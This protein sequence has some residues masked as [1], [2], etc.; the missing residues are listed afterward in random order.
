MAG[1]SMRST[2][3]RSIVEPILNQSFDGVYDQRTDEYKQIFTEE[4]G[5]K[6]AYHEE[7]A[8]VDDRPVPDARHVSACKAAMSEG[9]SA[10]RI[11]A[12]PPGVM[13]STVSTVTVTVTDV[14]P[15]VPIASAGM[16]TC[17]VARTM[18][19]L[20]PTGSLEDAVKDAVALTGHLGG[21]ERTGATRPVAG[22]RPGWP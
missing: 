9:R 2:Q 19:P 18:T 3:F 4:N 22:P 6:R 16:V 17:R 1:T 8:P 21:V 13:T 14:S 10:P 5:I 12:V 11:V 20:S 7:P 15:A